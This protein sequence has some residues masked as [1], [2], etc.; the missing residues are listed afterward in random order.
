MSFAEKWM[1]LKIFMLSEVRQIQKDK[2]QIFVSHTENLYIHI[3]VYICI[4]M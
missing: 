2:Y 4:Y 3:Y 1:E